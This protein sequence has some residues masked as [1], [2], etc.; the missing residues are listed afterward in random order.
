MNACDRIERVVRKKSLPPQVAAAAAA[1]VVA[2][3][4]AGGAVAVVATALRVVD[5]ASDACM[6]RVV[7]E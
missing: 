6:N 7:N 4:A 3:A 2:A 1:A 5:A